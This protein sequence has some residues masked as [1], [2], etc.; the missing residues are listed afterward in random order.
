MKHLVIIINLTVGVIAAITT[1]IM[2]T[3]GLIGRDHGG[4]PQLEL[5]ALFL[6]IFLLCLA[7]DW[8]IRPRVHE[9][10]E[11]LPQDWLRKARKLGKARI[12]IRRTRAMKA[13]SF[14]FAG[15]CLLP[16]VLLVKN[17]PEALDF[18]IGLR[19]ELA[20]VAGVSLLIALAVVLRGKK[21]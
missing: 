20:F 19:S 7:I 1:G 16:G 2:L 12:R 5:S 10:E 14:I 11:S 6:G 3:F 18:V 13:L 21:R 4:S 15:G 17:D 9:E 8:I